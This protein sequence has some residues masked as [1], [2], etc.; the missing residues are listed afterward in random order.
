MLNS[1]NI[2][3][4]VWEKS[5]K[6]TILF[7]CF[8]LLLSTACFREAEKM[9]ESESSSS[10]DFKTTDLTGVSKSVSSSKNWSLATSKVYDFRTCIKTKVTNS[11]LGPGH[12]FNITRPDQRIFHSVTDKKGCINWQENIQFNISSDSKYVELKRTLSGSNIYKGNLDIRIGINPWSEFRSESANEVVNLDEQTLPSSHLI[13]GDNSNLA[14]SGLYEKSSGQDLLI[15]DEPSTEIKFIKYQ[16]KAQI[17]RVTIKVK[18]F[19]EPLD[20]SGSPAPYYFKKGLFTVYPQLVANYLGS[21]GEQKMILMNLLPEDLTVSRNGYLIYQKEVALNREVTMGEVQLALKV[22][23]KESPVN[24]N[25]YEGLHSLGRFGEI[26]GKHSVTQIQGVYSSKLFNYAK[27]I[28]STSNFKDLKKQSI[29]F[30]L[31]PVRFKKLSI[32]F[33]RVAPGETATR[34]TII[35]RN[36]TQVVDTITGEPVKKQ[37]FRIQK[38][39]TEIVETRSDLSGEAQEVVYTDADGILKWTDEISHLFYAAEQFY[40][41]EVKL[42]H[43]NSNYS[44]SLKMAINPWNSGWTF[45]TDYRG[46]EEDY[47]RMNLL[48]KKASTFLLDAFRYQTIRFR[49]EIDEFMTLNVKKAVVMAIDPVTQRYTIEEGRKVSEPLRDGIYLVKVALVKYFIDPFTSGSKLYRDENDVHRV[50]QTG[51]TS[52][53]KK[54]EYIT[55][56]KKL[57]RVQGGRITTPI[58]FSMRDLRMMSIRSNIM[59]QIETI[60]EQKLLRDNL[61][62]RKLR[63]LV[64][65]YNVYNSA[66]M[67]DEEKEAFMN[68]NEELFVSEKKKLSDAM[69][70][71]LADLQNHRL[72]LSNAE[73]E[74][75]K[76]LNDF[77]DKIKDQQSV[78]DRRARRLE[79]LNS[80]KA[81]F[82]EYI[83][84]V[85]SNLD[86]MEK[87]FSNH[88][89]QWNKDMGIPSNEIQD[90]SVYKDGVYTNTTDDNNNPD[91]ERIGLGQ[92]KSVY[93][94]L[95]SMQ[96]FMTDHGLPEDLGIDDLKAMRL[97][98]YTQNPAAPFIDLDLYKNNAGLKR[99]TFIGP[100]TLIANDNMSEM[101]PTDTIDETYCK[102][103]DCSQ[104]LIDFGFEV[105]NSKFEKSA[106]HGA[107]KPFAMTHVDNIINMYEKHERNYYEGMRALSQMGRFLETYNLEYT[108]LNNNSRVERPQRF[109]DIC[110]VDKSVKFNPKD[111]DGCFEEASEN[112]VPFYKFSQRLEKSDSENLLLE[113]FKYQFFEDDVKEEGLT[114]TLPS[115]LETAGE[116]MGNLTEDMQEKV[117]GATLFEVVRQIFTND[118]DANKYLE[119]FEEGKLRDFDHNAL[120]GMINSKTEDLSLLQAVKLCG[121]LTEGIAS[122]LRSKDLVKYDK[123]IRRFRG[124]RVIRPSGLRETKLIEKSLREK[125][126][127]SIEFDPA[128]GTIKSPAISFDRRYRVIETGTYEHKEGKN[129]NLNVGYDFQ[130]GDGK[131]LAVSSALGVNAAINASVTGSLGIAEI[132]VSGAATAGKEV[133]ETE[134][135]EITRGSSVGAATF[136]VVQQ[137]TMEIELRKFERCF[138]ANLSP[139]IFYDLN[140]QDLKLVDGKA[141]T[142]TDV[143]KAL[144]KGL[145][146]CSGKYNR[147]PEKIIENYY[148]ITQHFTAGDMLDEGNLLNHIWLLP[149]RGEKDFHNF[150][151]L[152]NAKQI[153][154]D[155]EV[156]SEEDRIIYPNVRLKKNYEQVIPS[157]P[158]LYTVQQEE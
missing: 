43:V 120:N 140:A 60:D 98:N 111:Y 69:S 134:V 64:D 77:E 108:S 92:N 104:N 136:L 130:V 27:Y 150:M 123:T 157:F 29:A 31:K 26:F 133:S 110:I 103:I 151:R 63:E 25:D 23:A 89:R 127:K 152:V 14:L 5:M 137:A 12:K 115:L 45:G 97:N 53:T 13:S 7:I 4:N 112:I 135:T 33:V 154:K 38:S 47:E 65:E 124:Q 17:V 156:I 15:D 20:M 42:T 99:R 90:W 75:Y 86:S 113:F 74:R 37:A 138:T 6:S 61:V 106:H 1:K 35:F 116:E 58:E 8:N 158:G 118:S 94:Y 80:N 129:M 24:F 87:S 122:E 145:M 88:W 50:V 11:D 117:F 126:L 51:E 100:C 10:V 56:I 83:T 132:G 67:T 2:N 85:R 30:D 149:L 153:D 34:R 142:D 155:G 62:D 52:E 19:I 114:N 144:S 32:R 148:Y 93:D 57:L 141:V 109:K 128:T 119:K 54:G 76:A 71:E 39:L 81:E 46:R 48:E 79:I 9:Q 21:T 91:K 107:L 36:E 139:T 95:A 82:D 66:D 44:E 73:A 18:P 125:C 40:Y 41:P 3:K 147:K 96:V 72:K 55:V 70:K 78:H 59:V 121:V 49:Y 84:S 146:V 16:D 131:V 101:R 102:R 22:E 68:K 28:K 105:D 143:S